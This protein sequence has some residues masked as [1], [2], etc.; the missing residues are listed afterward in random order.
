VGTT[1]GLLKSNSIRIGSMGGVAEI[2][3]GLSVF[4]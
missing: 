1:E 4:L 3:G 2:I